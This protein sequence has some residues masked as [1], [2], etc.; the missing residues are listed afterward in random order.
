MG[1]QHIA[2]A[3]LYQSVGYL[4]RRLRPSFRRP[5]ANVQDARALKAGSQ[6]PG[7]RNSLRGVCHR[8]PHSPHSVDDRGEGEAWEYRTGLLAGKGRRSAQT[9]SVGGERQR[10]LDS[11]FQ[12]QIQNRVRMG[13]G[14]SE[15]VLSKD[16]RCLEVFQLGRVRALEVLD[17]RLADIG[18]TVLGRHS[19]ERCEYGKFWNLV[20]RWESVRQSFGQFTEPHFE[21]K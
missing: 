16:L 10:E 13:L 5:H 17:K 3:I 14:R 7:V 4:L 21:G 6:V 11:M 20:P 18:E 1:S 9:S 19:Q 12:E 15:Y 8:A 2:F